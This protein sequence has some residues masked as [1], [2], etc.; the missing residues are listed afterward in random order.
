MIF[1]LISLVTPSFNVILQDDFVQ[2]IDSEGPLSIKAANIFIDGNAELAANAT[3]GNGSAGNPYIIE[4]YVINATGLGADGILIQNTTAHFILRNCT[5]TDAF[6]G[7]A[8][9]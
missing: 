9:I 6:F 5:I 7:S 4:N 2:V 3:T 8:G 1:V